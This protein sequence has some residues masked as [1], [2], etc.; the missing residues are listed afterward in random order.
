MKDVSEKDGSR[1]A[2]LTV[3]CRHDDW[4]NRQQR[5]TRQPPAGLTH[6]PFDPRAQ[7]CFYKVL[8]YD[9]TCSD[10]LDFPNPSTYPRQHIFST[11]FL[12]RNY[13]PYLS[14]FLFTRERPLISGLIVASHVYLDS[15]TY[16]TAID[17]FA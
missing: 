4:R 15:C 2:T 6:A 16:N 17:L 7:P 1:N 8:P 10:Y 3:Q 5:A 14:F 13:T 12:D 11:I 9:T